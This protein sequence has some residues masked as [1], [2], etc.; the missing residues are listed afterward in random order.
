MKQ[1]IPIRIWFLHKGGGIP[2]PT[3]LPPTPAN[4]PPPSPSSPSPQRYHTWDIK[5]LTKKI[6]HYTLILYG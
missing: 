6:E 4:P 3:S 5:G 1:E 2:P